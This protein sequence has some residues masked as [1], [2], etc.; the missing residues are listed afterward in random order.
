M[1]CAGPTPE[2]GT[3][4]EVRSH[5]SIPGSPVTQCDTNATTLRKQNS[6]LHVSDPQHGATHKD[7]SRR[8]CAKDGAFGGHPA[9]KRQ[10]LTRLVCSASYVG[11]LCHTASRYPNIAL[12]PSRSAPAWI[13]S[14]ANSLVL[15]PPDAFTL[16]PSPTHA[17]RFRTSSTVAPPPAKPVE[18]LI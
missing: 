11:A 8:Q 7:V 13:N 14:S 1:E 15:I 10:E 12:V 4:L 9:P 17:L 2:Q 18:V 16:T 3:A 5:V 6:K